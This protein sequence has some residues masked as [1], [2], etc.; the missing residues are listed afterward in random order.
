MH[1]V[2]LAHGR[3]LAFHLER[4][5]QARS[6][7]QF[8][9]P[10]VHILPIS[11]GSTSVRGPRG[12]IQAA[13]QPAALL[14]S[15]GRNRR[16]QLVWSLKARHGR[17]IRGR[18]DEQRAVDQAQVTP[19]AD[20][21]GAEDGIAHAFDQ[22]HVRRHGALCGSNLRQDGTEVRRVGGRI[23]L[24]AQAVVHGVEMVADVSDMRHRPDQAEMLG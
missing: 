12:M 11:Q 24:A 15:T 22:P 2:T 18:A 6:A 16:K 1:T 7:R 3:G 14:H 21:R 10:A 19:I 20:V 23:R 17:V 13:Q 5:A 8:I 4:L 9:G